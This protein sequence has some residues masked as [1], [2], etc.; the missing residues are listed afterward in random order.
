MPYLG[1]YAKYT[2]K[3]CDVSLK[4]VR[5]ADI[6]NQVGNE[7]QKELDKIAQNIVTEIIS[8]KEKEN[9]IKE[10]KTKIDNLLELVALG[11][12]SAK[13]VHSKIEA[14]QQ[15]INEIQLTE[16]MNTKATERLR[17]SDRLPIVY[18][19]LSTDEK[20]SICQQMIEKIL[21]SSS[22]DMEIVW[23]I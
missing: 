19:R 17:I 22:G 8:D 16:F 1:C 2:L 11:G 13:T 20:K 10:L 15:E 14:L 4:G 21:L 23:K 5:F 12:E 3:T 6:Q 7:V 18:D 9:H